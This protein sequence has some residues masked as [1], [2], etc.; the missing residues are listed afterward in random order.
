MIVSSYRRKLS[1]ALTF[2][3]GQDVHLTHFLLT[4]DER[5]QIKLHPRS[6]CFMTL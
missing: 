5:L 3:N 1:C 2:T 4:D 6:F